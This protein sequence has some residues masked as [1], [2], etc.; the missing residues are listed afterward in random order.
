MKR[1]AFLR[2]VVLAPWGLRYALADAAASAAGPRSRGI[3]WLLAH[4]S[5]DGSWRSARYGAF[6]D[7]RAL[8]PLVLRALS[9][10]EGN[11]NACKRACDWLLAQGS[12][13]FDAYPVHLSSEILGSLPRCPVLQP[14]AE[15]ARTRLLSLQCP[16]TGGWSYAH[17]PPPAEGELSP[18]HQANL[19][20]T[21]MAVEGLRAAGL[22]AGD[23]A[24][25]RALPFVGSC[26][27]QATGERAFDD[28][29][30]FEMPDDP[31]RN[32]AGSAGVD[33]SGKTRYRSYASATADGLRA[34]L[35][36]GEDPRS[37]RVVAA[38]EWLKR[39]RWRVEGGKDSP[40]DLSYYTARSIARCEV[41]CPGVVEVAEG[42]PKLLT[43]A[44]ETDGSWCNTAGEMREDCPVVATALAL[45]AV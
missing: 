7:G 33:V 39:F 28:G 8:T 11:E 42:L 14:L 45:G 37:E 6:R 12:S 1:S 5:P 9:S 16:R 22:K 38:V 24:I 18:M 44:Q 13:L 23:A 32:K 19:A 41:L 27:N 29:G 43:E 34:M 30:F 31:A 15:V 3:G 21:T 25:R 20:A 2:I 40:A 4:Q 36:C 35:L 26:Q 10:C 17:T